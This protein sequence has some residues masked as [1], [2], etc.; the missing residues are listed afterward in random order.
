MSARSPHP[1]PRLDGEG[2][3]VAAEYRAEVVC[4]LLRLSPAKLRRYERRGLVS[5][6]RAGRW[7]VYDE[8]AL[9]RLRRLRRLT[10][11]LGVNLAGAEIILRLVD[12]LAELRARSER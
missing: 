2:T 8:A 3:M 4:Q 1:G 7:R 10:E 12:E 9:Q 11:D 6:R 5:P